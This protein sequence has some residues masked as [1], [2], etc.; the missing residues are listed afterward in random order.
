M[1]MSLEFLEQI[2]ELNIMFIIWIWCNYLLLNEINLATFI[3][4]QINCS[5]HF[6]KIITCLSHP[7]SSANLMCWLLSKS[8][9]KTSKQFMVYFFFNFEHSQ[10]INLFLLLTSNM[11]LSVGHRKQI[12][13][14]T[15]VYI[16]PWRSP[17]LN[18][19]LETL[20]S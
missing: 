11:Y 2:S 5:L 18:N 12:H 4:K 20:G 1:I 14:T 6:Q 16:K 13:K 19:L 17:W 9:I 10:Q 15:Y 7:S 3:R 8:T